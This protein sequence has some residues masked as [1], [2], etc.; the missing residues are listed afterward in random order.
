MV[1]TEDRI[2]VC[3]DRIVTHHQVAANDDPNFSLSPSL[4]QLYELFTGHSTSGLFGLVSLFTAWLKQDLLY[5]RPPCSSG[6]DAPS[7]APSKSDLVQYGQRTR[8]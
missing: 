3:L 7:S 5:L 4:V 8:R 1:V 6:K 2:A